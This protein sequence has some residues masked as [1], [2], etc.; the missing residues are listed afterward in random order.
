[1]SNI[2]NL[3]QQKLIRELGTFSPNIVYSIAPKH[4]VLRGFDY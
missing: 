2:V 4:Y 3:N 1:M